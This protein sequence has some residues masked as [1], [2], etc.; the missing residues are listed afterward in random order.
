MTKHTRTAIVSGDPIID[1]LITREKGERTETTPQ[2]IRHT[3]QCSWLPGGALLLGELINR[4]APH[5]F[6]VKKF[7]ITEDLLRPTDANFHHNYGT[8]RRYTHKDKPA[9]WRV[10]DVLGFKELEASVGKEPLWPIDKY[11]NAELVIIDDP[12]LAFRN[13]RSQWPEEI[14]KRNSPATVILKMRGELATGALW[15]QLFQN[16]AE[17]LV[18]VTT[19][20]DAR[21]T[22]EAEVS[23][24]ISWE[25]T[26]RQLAAELIHKP[27]INALSRCACTVISFGPAGAL[28]F[29]G[30]FSSEGVKPQLFFDPRN[31]EGEREDLT[32]GRMWGY[33][34]IL[35]AA[36]SRKLMT[37]GAGWTN[38][39]ISDA[40]PQALTAMRVLDDVGYDYLGKG[41][42]IKFPF[43]IVV[44]AITNDT[45]S[46]EISM[47]NVPPPTLLRQQYV[48]GREQ[49]SGS[50]FWTILSDKYAPQKLDELAKAIVEEGPRCVDE[51]P[52]GSFGELFTLDRQEIESFRSIRALVREYCRRQ[53]S[54]SD[55]PLS[56]AVFGQPGDGKSF[57]VRQL[58]DSLQKPDDPMKPSEKFEKL[59]FNLSQFRSTDDLIHAFHLVRDERLGGNIPLVFWDEFDTKLNGDV[60]GWLRYFLAPMQD[61]EF[62]E[63]GAFHRVG[64]S[65]F[66]FAGGTSSTMQAFRKKTGFVD[67]KGPDFL[68]RIRGY[69]DIRAVNPESEGLPS[70][71]NAEEPNPQNERVLAAENEKRNETVDQYYIVRR[72]ILLRSILSGKAPQLFDGLDDDEKGS[73]NLHIASAVL[74]AFLEVPRYH[75][76]AR[77]IEAIV[78]M[79]ALTGKHTFGPS[80][81]PDKE[82]LD[83]HVDGQEFLKIV[84]RVDLPHRVGD[85]FDS[86]AEI[87]HERFRNIVATMTNGHLEEYKTGFADTAYS[88]VTSEDKEQYRSFVREAA[89][90]LEDVGCRVVPAGKGEQVRALPPEV[91]EPLAKLEHERWMT[92]MHATGWKV[93]DSTNVETRNHEALVAWEV[94]NRTQ[95]EIDRERVKTIPT[96]LMDGASLMVE[97]Y[98]TDFSELIS[99]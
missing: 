6:D 5:Y 17:R 88:K 95:K 4:V 52:V 21:R 15:D 87:A 45:D 7:T 78:D 14:T 24:D 37:I 68:S 58:L 98:T 40:I 53:P 56:I 28:F 76:G 93:G 31:T 34:S 10:E 90:M 59:H 16:F 29:P 73:G 79:S 97:A 80:C 36:I 3:S 30:P 92:H 9:R 38:N 19:I 22:K 61:G 82:Q 47:A 12:D 49:A 85:G 27:S 13:H 35:A 75:H 26:A 84:R 74:R 86:L 81:L 44:N 25:Q 46:A 91:I 99:S 23:Q 32:S 50:R 83:P 94:L 64:R 55:K 57:A 89:N 11:D 71:E 77:S 2:R 60:L 65:I 63:R 66:V 72:A 41:S 48:N 42:V 96:I 33:A 39:V 62:Q 18:V 69:I 67:A 20:K 1:W 51:V 70:P 54:G 43:D 8:L